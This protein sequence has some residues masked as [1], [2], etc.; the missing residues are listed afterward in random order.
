MI[1]PVKFIYNPGDK[2]KLASRMWQ[3]APSMEKTGNRIW[4][5]WFSGGVY[6]P[7]SENYG[8][9]AYSDDE[10]AN[11]TEPYMILAGEP[12]DGQRVFEVQFWQEPDGRL[13]LFWGQDCHGGYLKTD[14]DTDV[15]A[16]AD[17]FFKDLQV[18]AVY[19]DNPEAENP[20]WSEP[21]YYG[22]GILRNNPTALKDGRWLIPTYEVKKDEKY[23]YML[24]CDKGET[25]S[26][27]EGPEKI[28]KKCWD[29]PMFVEKKN[30]DWWMLVRTLNG[31]IAESISTDQGKTWSKMQ[32]TIHPNPSTRFY[33][34]RL[35]NG[36]LLLVNT[37]SATLGDRKSLVAFLSEDDGKTWPHQL[38]L[39]ERRS[40]TYPDVAM[41]GDISFMI[42]R[43]TTGRR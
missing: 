23:Q 31:D 19:T 35:E 22:K 15:E 41:D 26:V 3:G 39:D 18:W 5:A 38:L 37:P 30:G 9:I 34:G 2:Y 36:M 42:A 14:F 20:T 1:K 4:A 12:E 40:T 13:W 8:I 16:L 33:I 6:E 11:W 27:L 10:G 17:M 32:N 43:E 25:V 7:S 21:K 29:E 28:S 24:S